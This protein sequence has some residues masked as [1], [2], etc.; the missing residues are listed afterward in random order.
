MRNSF[1][2]IILIF[3]HPAVVIGVI[4]LSLLQAEALLH[5]LR[6]AQGLSNAINQ[7]QLS[8]LESAISVVRNGGWEGELEKQMITALNIVEKV[9]VNALDVAIIL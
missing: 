2:E 3:K 7:R 6:A 1:R 9:V 8:A 4:V 5:K